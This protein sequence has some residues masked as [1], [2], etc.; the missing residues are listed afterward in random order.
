MGSIE[1][2]VFIHP[3]VHGK[4]EEFHYVFTSNSPT[5]R[6]NKLKGSN[7]F[8]GRAEDA[9]QRLLV[10]GPKGN[11]NARE[12]SELFGRFEVRLSLVTTIESD[13]FADESV[14]H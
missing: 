8:S 1:N 6:G 2:M 9:E 14:A 11:E 13:N 12:L 3:F 5:D 10:P 7:E 4:E